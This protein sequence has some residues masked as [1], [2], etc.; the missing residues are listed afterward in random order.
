MTRLAGKFAPGTLGSITYKDATGRLTTKPQFIPSMPQSIAQTIS[1]IITS[2][3]ISPLTAGQQQVQ[4]QQLNNV[5]QTSSIYQ[6][7]LQR[8]YLNNLRVES[9]SPG[10]N[11][12]MQGLES[13][14]N[15]YTNIP[16]QVPQSLD[17]YG[18]SRGSI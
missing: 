16:L 13:T 7:S 5:D 14:Y 10:T 12:Q 3:A 17:P 8:D 15:P 1:P 9:L 11:F 18:L 2:L 6:Q 4:Q